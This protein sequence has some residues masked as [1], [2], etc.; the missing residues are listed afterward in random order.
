MSGPGSSARV[1]LSRAEIIAV[2]TELLTP[3]RTD[4]NSL[5]LT[6]RL[7]E[8][9]IEV[10]RK[11]IVGDDTA[12]LA[13][14]VRD[15]L[16]RADLLVVCGGLGP[17]EDDRTR[18]TVAEV[19][20]LG[21]T[22]ERAIVE[23]L[24][25]RFATRGWTMPENNR[26]QGM[27]PD[28]AVV[29]DNPRGTAPGLW[30]ESGGRVVVLLPGPPRELEPMFTA[31]A[32]DRLSKYTASDRLYRRI[33]RLAGR[34]ESH[35]EELAQ[36][37]YE[38]WRRATPPVATTVL[39]SPGLVELHLSTRSADPDTATVVL[40]GAT[41]ELA[42]VLGEHL[43][44][45]DGRSL[46]EV[47]GQMLHGGGFRVAV[48]ESCTGGL[49]T[50]E[51]VDVPGSSS[52]VETGVVAY[53]NEVKQAVLGVDPDLIESAGAVS[54]AV[55]VAMAEGAQRVGA[56]DIGIGVTGVAGPGGG[57]DEKP[58]GTVC[59]GVVGPGTEREA[60]TVR[61]P[62]DRAMIRRQAARTALDLLRRVLQRR[63]RE[64]ATIRGSES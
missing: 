5:F 32:L 10:R 14:A 48:G 38:R 53:S 4:T 20:G 15:A 47:V 63:L 19:L 1:P 56:V 21:L 29:L 52:Y 60:R 16:E 39:A 40:D 3:F 2:G 35:V 61:F 28:G 12:D 49:V 31:V 24:R 18:E 62:G 55:A 51:L 22:E 27:V 13:P 57:S 42:V 50:A 30:L 33:L 25:E 7:N 46:S 54:E 45:T 26:R 36:P 9:G 8:L 34:G 41:A 17:T 64:R 23:R 43:V 11:S 59:F 58:V 6:A 44:S 37:V